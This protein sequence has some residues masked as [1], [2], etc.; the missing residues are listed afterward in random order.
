MRVHRLCTVWPFVSTLS[1]WINLLSFSFG[2]W[3]G[4]EP[5]ADAGKTWPEGPEWEPRCHAW[6]GTHDPGVQEAF[7]GQ[8]SNAVGH[9]LVLYGRLKHKVVLISVPPHSARHFP[10]NNEIFFSKSQVFLNFISIHILKVRLISQP[11]L[12]VCMAWFLTW[13]YLTTFYWLFF[14]LA[15]CSCYYGIMMNLLMIQTFFL[16]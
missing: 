5:E 1:W 6:T 7:Q 15:N 2:L 3:Q 4:D 9:K 12:L 16:F 13:K 10:E 14:L 11:K 8:F